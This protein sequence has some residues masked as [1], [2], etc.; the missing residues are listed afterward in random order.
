MGIYHNQVGGLPE[1]QAASGVCWDWHWD[2]DGGIKVA[3]QT[4]SLLKA[5]NSSLHELVCAKGQGCD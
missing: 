1:G 5:S 3:Y 2:L 4:A